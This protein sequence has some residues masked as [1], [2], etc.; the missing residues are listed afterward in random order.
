MHAMVAISVMLELTSMLTAIIAIF[1]GKE[2]LGTA[3]LFG[4]GISSLVVSFFTM[5]FL[6]ER[7]A[8]AYLELAD[9]NAR[10]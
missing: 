6:D 8:R 10:H 4:Y 7:A 3:I 9:G 5:R 2:H 1:S